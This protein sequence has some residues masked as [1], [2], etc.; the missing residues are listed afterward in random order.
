[1]SL[2]LL[3]SVSAK[4][5]CASC[6]PAYLRFPRFSCPHPASSTRSRLGGMD[7]QLMRGSPF[8]CCSQCRSV[9]SSPSTTNPL[10]THLFLNLS[11]S[12]SLSLRHCLYVSMSLSLYTLPKWFL[13]SCPGFRSLMTHVHT[14]EEPT[15]PRWSVHSNR[16]SLLTYPGCTLAQLHR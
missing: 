2:R 4:G 14:P 11:L 6:L 16:I 5:F 10:V 7:H 13:C 8:V 3:L 12:L 1:M 9:C 15:N